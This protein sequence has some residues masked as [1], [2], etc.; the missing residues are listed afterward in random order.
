[1]N[2]RDA[3][4]L[5]IPILLAFVIFSAGVNAGTIPNL[6]RNNT[7]PVL[8]I[9]GDNP[10]TVQLGT[11]YNDSGATAW[12]SYDGNITYKISE[13]NFVDTS[14]IG[15]YYVVYAVTDYA[16]NT[17]MANRTVYVMPANQTPA[18]MDNA[19]DSTNISMDN[20]SAVAD[21]TSAITN[22]TSANPPVNPFNTDTGTTP[23]TGSSISDLGSTTNIIIIVAIVIAIILII[24]IA[25]ASKKKKNKMNEGSMPEDKKI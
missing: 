14:T 22:D 3:L 5:A 11:Y 10:A 21:N 4:L 12:D 17:A 2:K 18:I 20:T 15:T 13:T 8:T 7:S 23:I 6:Y 24:I 25:R 1:M 9:T 16:G 19:T